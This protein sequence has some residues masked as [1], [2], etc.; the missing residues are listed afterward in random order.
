M[1]KINWQYGGLMG[2]YDIVVASVA[3]YATVFLLSK[4]LDEFAIGLFTSVA[5]ILAAFLQP[6][7]GA[8]VDK[9]IKL[10]LYNVNLL[11]VLPSIILLIAILLLNQMMLLVTIMYIFVVMLQVT[12]QPFMNAIGV[13]LMN[14]G[15]KLNFGVCR[16]MESGSFAIT[17]TIV[18]LLISRLGT[19]MIIVVALVGYSI[20]LFVLWFLNKRFLADLLNKNQHGIKVN[21]VD[22]ALQPSIEPFFTKYPHFKFI[23]LGSM[24]FYVG[25]NFINLFMIQILANVGGNTANMGFAIALAAIV[26]MPI[27]IFFT[28]INRRFSSEHLLMLS[29]VFFFLK[30]TLTFAATN[31][32]GIYFAQLTQIFAFGLYI[33]AIVYYTNQ[34]MAQEDK[35]KGQ[36][37]I[38]TSHTVG[39]VIGSSVGG[40]ILQ[41]FSVEKGL[42]FAI[43]IS[44]I[45]ATAYYIALIHYTNKKK[46]LL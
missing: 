37:L 3:A 38:T 21:S 18:G 28:R 27:M 25:H 46:V 20:Y 19:D 32:M 17:S 15:L 44:L 5:S 42:L 1:D 29:A 13:F 40:W 30:T 22:I 24:C 11:I 41:T 45:G 2:S 36:A 10:T 4:G 9:G 39:S 26:E 8:Q 34:S 14:S 12:L 33:V 16:A 31:V 6:W 7:I 43:V 23:A 35:V